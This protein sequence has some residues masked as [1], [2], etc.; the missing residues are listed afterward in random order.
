MVGTFGYMAPEYA[1][2]GK[3]ST[4]TDVYAFGVVLLQ[5]ITGL[6]NTDNCL[7]D[8]SLVE[9]VKIENIISPYNTTCLFCSTKQLV[10]KLNVIAL[11]AN[12]NL[13][14]LSTAGNASSGAKELSTSN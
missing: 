2:S 5:L 4:K 14:Y 3:F 8:K 1:A 7:E 9:W 12:D 13:Y 11:V 6:K 10:M